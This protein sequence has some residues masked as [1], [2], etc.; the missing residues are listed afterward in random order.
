LFVTN[1]SDSEAGRHAGSWGSQCP[2][3]NIMYVSTKDGQMGK[4]N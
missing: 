1:G 4:E 3:Q 2:R